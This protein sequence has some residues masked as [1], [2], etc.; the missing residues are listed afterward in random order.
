MIVL[1]QVF[2]AFIGYNFIH[3]FEKLAFPYLAIVFCIATLVILTQSNPSVGFNPKAP[4]AFGGASA[5]F[6]LAAFISFAYAAGW[7]PYS[8]DFARYLAPA[9]RSRSASTAMT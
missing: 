8:M 4:V 2:V 5:A 1:V 6:I 3:Q 9:V 7:A